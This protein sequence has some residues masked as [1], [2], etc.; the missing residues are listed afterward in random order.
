MI[1]LYFTFLAFACAL[2]AVLWFV[3]PGLGA[4]TK[5]LIAAGVFLAL[6][7]AATVWVNWAAQQMPDDAQVIIPRK[8]G[9]K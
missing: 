1:L 5:L 6:S 7:V 3:A 9:D 4:W 8:N 2:F